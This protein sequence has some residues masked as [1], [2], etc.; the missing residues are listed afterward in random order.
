MVGDDPSTDAGIRLTLEK[1]TFQR[2]CPDPYLDW[3][4]A[5]E[6]LRRADAER[7][8]QAER[9][10]PGAEVVQ[11]Q[12]YAEVPQLPQGPMGFATA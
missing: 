1:G 9:G 3:T 4:G 8:L 10:S 11:R 5:V 6:D 2:P 12:P 7:E